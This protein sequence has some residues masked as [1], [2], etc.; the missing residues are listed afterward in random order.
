MDYPTGF[1]WNVIVVRRRAPLPRASGP[2]HWSKGSKRSVPLDR[3]LKVTGGR[4][5]NIARL[6]EALEVLSR[7]GGGDRYHG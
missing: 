5:E 4:A 6:R 3:G 7:E 2:P 1:F